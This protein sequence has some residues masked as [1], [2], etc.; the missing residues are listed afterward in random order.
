[1][2]ELVELEGCRTANQLNRS[3]LRRPPVSNMGIAFRTREFRHKPLIVR[4]DIAFGFRID[5]LR[6]RRPFAICLEA[7]P[8]KIAVL[9]ALVCASHR[10]QQ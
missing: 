6:T 4:I 8:H 7:E 1:M 5:E 3:G 9:I 2:Q 10:N